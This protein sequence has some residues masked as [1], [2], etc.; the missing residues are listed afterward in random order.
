LRREHRFP[1]TEPADIGRDDIEFSFI[2][3]NSGALADMDDVA[4]AARAGTLVP[5]IE[6]RYD[7]DHAVDAVCT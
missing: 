7:L 2:L 4:K 3:D 5:A 1:R 6:E